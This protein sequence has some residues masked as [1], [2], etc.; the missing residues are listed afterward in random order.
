MVRR[1][2]ETRKP[3]GGNLVSQTRNGQG[4]YPGPLTI[5]RFVLVNLRSNPL[6]LAPDESESA[7][8]YCG[9]GLSGDDFFGL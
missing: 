7:F 4:G 5:R 6:A 2:R 9:S 3:S 8:G 1:V